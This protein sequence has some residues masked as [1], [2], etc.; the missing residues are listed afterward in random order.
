MMNGMMGGMWIWL[1][2]GVLL[3]V[4][5]VD[6]LKIDRSFIHDMP[7]DANDMAITRAI[8]LLAHSLKQKV[9]AEGVETAE[10]LAYLR[11]E[12]CDEM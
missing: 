1:I 12:N 8:I 9:V 11:M 6:T 3:I 10:Q 7:E 2:V 4:F 5:L